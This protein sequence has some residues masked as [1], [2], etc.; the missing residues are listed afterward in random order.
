MKPQNKFQREVV[1]LSKTLPF[2][3]EEQ[4]QW[5]YTNMFRHAAVRLKSG[6]TTCLECG[7][8]WQS[9]NSLLSDTICGTEC[10]HCKAQLEILQ[11]RRTKFSEVKYLCIVTTHKGFQVMR[12][13]YV[14]QQEQV[15]KKVFYFVKEVIQHWLS[16]Q[17][18]LATFKLLQ[19]MGYWRDRW[20]WTSEL[21][22]RKNDVSNDIVPHAIYPNIQTIKE[23]KR[24]GFKKSFHNLTPLEM[25]QSILTN[26]KAETLLKTKQKNLLYYF[27]R[28]SLYKLDSYWNSIRIATKNGYIVKDASM[29]CDYIDL[30]NYF[31]KDVHSAKYICPL[32]LKKEHDRLVLK[33]AARI[34]K[35]Q[36]ELKKQRAIENEKRFKELKSKFFGI[37][38]TDGLIKVRVL[39]SVLEFA[40]E[41]TAMHHCVFSNEYYLKENS[42]ILSATING[43]RIETIE[44]SLETLRVMQSRGVCNNNTEYHNQIIELVNQNTNLIKQRMAS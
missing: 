9:D 4:K 31:G 7:A 3:T 43:K 1:E 37:E 21:E 28:K 8:S 6:K 26:N 13:F 40:E 42:L 41:G 29:W 33:K 12:F 38:F 36:F 24:N 2:I 11:S 17:G 22:L 16:P 23:V 34:A 20:T 25:F 39:E 32:N 18:K 27:V 10:P 30:L 14:E 15:G 19:P 5:A 44:I 35:E